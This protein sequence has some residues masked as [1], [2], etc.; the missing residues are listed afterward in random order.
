MAK[1][2]NLQIIPE[3]FGSYLTNIL[4]EDIATAAGAF[5][6]SMRQI[7]NIQAVPIEKFAQ[8]VPNIETTKGLNLV[9][10]TNVPTNETLSATG[11]DLIGLGGGPNGTYTMSDMLGAM[12]GLPYP[13]KDI[14]NLISSLQTTTL[15]NIY[16]QIFLAVTWEPAT[17]SIQYTTDLNLPSG[18]TTYTVTGVTITDAGGGYGINEAVAPVITITNGGGATAIATI[19]INDSIAGS[20]GGGTYG[21]VTAVQFTGGSPST[22]V[23]TVAIQTPPTAYNSSTNQASGTAGWPVAM[24]ATLQSYIDDA[25]DEI[26][27][28]KAGNATQSALLNKLYNITGLQLT[29]E[30][31]TRQLAFI[32]VPTPKDTTLSQFP[33][34]LYSF[35]DSIPQYATST[36][37]HMYAQTLEAISNLTT[38]GGQ[39][40]VAMMRQERNQFRL[41]STGIALDNNIPGEIDPITAKTLAAN[42][43]VPAYP[44]GYTLPSV[45]AG[46]IPAGYYDPNTDKYYTS[47]QLTETTSLGTMANEPILTDVYF[48]GPL[49]PG[50]G[51]ELDTGQADE[52]GSLAGSRYQNLVPTNL[53]T[54]YTS[55]V[56][57]PASYSVADAIDEVIKCNCDCWLI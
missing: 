20:N 41:S 55:K 23:P 21:R 3:G 17:L 35:V 54:A 46:A 51:K 29:R 43:S 44:S 57:T 14:Q 5:S 16:K 30:Q 7:R 1:S 47:D 4:P 36:L 53:N 28:I 12:S 19:G 26:I 13:W 10:G 11:N 15:Q 40:I 6:V 34:A 45:L 52:P 38:V 33:M 56:L 8:I 24:S 42:G 49:V 39:S 32:P 50:V 37:P 9:A 25:N 18:P 31:Q 48:T 22:S 2:V 27:N